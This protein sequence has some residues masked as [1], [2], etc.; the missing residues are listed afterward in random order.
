[1]PGPVKSI[2]YTTWML[3]IKEYFMLVKKN[4]HM[5]ANYFSPKPNEP[6]VPKFLTAYAKS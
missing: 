5:D 1:M 6:D 2:S 3:C 4:L